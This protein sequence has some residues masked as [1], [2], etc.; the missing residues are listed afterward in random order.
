MRTQKYTILQ[1]RI[2]NVIDVHR[3]SGIS[4]AEIIGVLEMVKLD[5]YEEA[6]EQEDH[7]DDD[8]AD[9]WKGGENP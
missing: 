4:I 8:S 6:L 2:E 9:D 3:G 1:N 7:T 5:M